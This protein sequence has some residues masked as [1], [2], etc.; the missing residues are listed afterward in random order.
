MVLDWRQVSNIN[1]KWISISELLIRIFKI[2]STLCVVRFIGPEQ[3]GAYVY[4]FAFGALFSIIYDPGISIFVLRLFGRRPKMSKYFPEM[5]L[6]K[7]FF[8]TLGLAAALTLIFSGALGG[9]EEIL[10]FIAVILFCLINELLNFL[11]VSLRGRGQTKT[12]ANYRF[13]YSLFSLVFVFWASLFMKTAMSVVIAQLVTS[14]LFFAFFHKKMTV[15]YHF[16]RAEVKNR[17]KIFN[18]LLI[19]SLPFAGVNAALIIYSNIDILILGAFFD[20]TA[21][22]SYGAV[23][24]L[25][26]L[27]QLPVV[28]VAQ[29]IYSSLGRD[30]ANKSYALK[31]KWIEIYELI[32][33]ACVLAMLLLFFEGNNLILLIGGSE[34]SSSVE[35]VL[36]MLVGVPGYF[37]FPIFAQLLIMSGKLKLCSVI[38]LLFSFFLGAGLYLAGLYGNF[39]LGL[40]TL[41]VMHL[42]LSLTLGAFL[43]RELRL[44]LVFPLITV[45][46]ARF[47]LI[48][49]SAFS[50][51]HFWELSIAMRCVVLVPVVL[52]ALWYYS[53][54]NESLK[55]LVFGLNPLR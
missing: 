34:F 45:K 53:S 37:T 24:R 23:I 26:M 8:L 25:F 42:L 28:I 7:L 35:M 29:T 16:S 36:V 14:V 12:E 39:N 15:N 11:F 51:A 50:F 41:A 6:L 54:G 46:N 22:G 4:A 1:L 43:K 55:R 47:L 33:L 9:R 2:V 3:Y 18:L 44:Q 30:I 40:Q 21:I 49:V 52:V 17:K 31:S 48:C 5:L 32:F 10:L 27:A 19:K 13:W 38:Y 20:E